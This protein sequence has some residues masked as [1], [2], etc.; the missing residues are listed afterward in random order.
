MSAPGVPRLLLVDDEGSV[1]TALHRALRQAFGTRLHVTP[2][3][4]PHAALALLR[5]E[6]FDVVLCDLRMPGLD[7]LA[8]LAQAAV[9][10]PHAVRMVLTASADFAAAQQAINGVG[11]FRF[12]SKPW[13]RVELSTHV[14]AA[15]AQ[16]RL[17]AERRA[18]DEARLSP[19]ERERRRLEALEPGLTQVE[20]GPLGEVV[21]DAALPP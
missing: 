13:G 9:L 17:Q 1:L 6:A 4:D 2:R 20:F 14:E 5:E 3:E 21:M 8:L 12:L 10:Q 11:V 19:Q 16:A 15:L 7:G 18:H